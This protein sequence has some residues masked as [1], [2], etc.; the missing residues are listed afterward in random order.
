MICTPH[1]KFSVNKIEK[2]K[3]GGN[4]ACVGDWIVLYRVC[5]SLE[6]LIQVMWVLG[7][8]YTAYVSA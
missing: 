8:S 4:V 3:M 7:V 2:K 5:R 6:C 1:P